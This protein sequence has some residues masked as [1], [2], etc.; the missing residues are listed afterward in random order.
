V[1][2]TGD[3]SLN[4]HHF[5]GRAWVDW[6]RAFRDV[7]I[8]LREWISQ[9]A[10]CAAHGPRIRQTRPITSGE[11]GVFLQEDLERRRDQVVDEAVAEA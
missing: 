4:P 7:E 10:C 11:W 1:I 2:A 9:L 5:V 8:R 6:H 3:D